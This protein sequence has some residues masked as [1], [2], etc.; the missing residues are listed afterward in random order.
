MISQQ[1]ARQAARRRALDTQAQVRIRRAEQDK[2]RRALTL[3]VVQALAKR[4]A[5]TLACEKR[6][7]QALVKLTGEEGLT[8]RDAVQWCGEDLTSRE[9]ARL[10]QLGQVDAVEAAAQER[11]AASKS[12][13][14]AG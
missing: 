7:G 4:D 5:T 12:E 13:P 8:L 6:A 11:Q 3:Q 1:M 9:V 14:A 10:R 2:R